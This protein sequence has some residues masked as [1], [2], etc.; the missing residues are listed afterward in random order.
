MVEV[1]GVKYMEGVGKQSGK[2]YKAYVVY[3]T[4]DGAA[5]GVDGFV[6]GDA[7]VNASLL[8]GRPVV[9][10][11]KLKFSYNKNGFLTSVEFC[12]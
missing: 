10:G 4:E 12:S 6:A 5:Q 3:Y 8:K 9:V 11:D 1:C 7:F 2:P